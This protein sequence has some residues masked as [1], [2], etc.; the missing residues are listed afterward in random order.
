VTQG[1]LCTKVARYPERVYDPDRVLYPM[2]RVG[3][4]GDGRFERISWDEA[5]AAITGR[6]KAIIA[7]DGPWAI[8][9]F[10]GSGTEGVVHGNIAGRRFFNRLGT[11]QLIRTICTRAGRIGYRYTMGS[12]MGADPCAITHTK[13]IV[14]WGI[15]TASTNIHHH[16]LLR[17]ARRNGAL[18]AVINPLRVNGAG[19]A[20]CVLQPRPGSDGALALGMM[21]VIIEEGLC[22]E[23][24]VSRFTFGFDKL[25]ERVKSYPPEK[26]ETFTDIAADDVKAFARLYADRKPSFIYVGPGCHRHTNGG[27]TVRTIAC[28]PALVGAWRQAGGGVYFPTSTVF[29]VDWQP[30]TGDELRPTPPAG[31]NMIHLG[32]MLTGSGPRIQSLYVF[33]GNPAT[34]L[35]NQN[36]L[37]RGLEREDLFTVVHEQFLTDTARYADLVLPA[38]TQFEHVDLLA[39]YYHLSLSLN[40]Q[41]IEPLGECKSNLDTFALLA[42]KLG[43]EDRCFRQDAWDVIGEAL[44]LDHPAL[45][46]VTL[47]RLLGEGFA[48]L[49]LET[50]HIPVRD[51]RFPTPSG[52]IEFYSE[53]MEGHGFDPLPAYVP[54][55]ESPEASPELFERYPLYF[56]TPSAHSFLNSNFGKDGG[57]TAA[58]Q[59]PTVVI[60]P[61]DAA[62]RGI[63]DGNLV[64]VV[65][66][67]GSC[68]LWARVS[69]DVRPGVTV[70]AGQWWSCHYPDRG[71]A[72]HTTPDFLADMAGGSAFNTNLV[73]VERADH[74]PAETGELRGGAA[75]GW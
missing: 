19:T 15:N 32:R 16:S 73:E 70:A 1:F 48:P 36:E 28:L 61:A 45:H 38:T 33:N 63:G 67:R 30:L 31:Y 47:E 62:P 72:N 51:G 24:F 34:V 52:K 8:L 54:V 7:E 64:R 37:R 42:Q 4:K 60:N 57:F 68:L 43:F 23:D 59:R 22:D 27:M 9:P 58:E 29:P 21:H 12:S 65:N 39:S 56:L 35:Y 14:A 44:A 71:N 10:F 2:K 49:R 40:Q 46:G 55:K 5:I 3:P 66:D 17:D 13:L 20:D 75:D 26:V 41:A 25:K 53:T 18:Y 69:G 50:P 11:L 74:P 6:W